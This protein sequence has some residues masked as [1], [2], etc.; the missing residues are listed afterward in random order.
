MCVVPVYSPYK[1]E[2]SDVW[3]MIYRERLDK[4]SIYG[5]PKLTKK[6]DLFF[7]PTWYYLYEF[8]DWG[9]CI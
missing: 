6:G 7:S 9:M 5:Q 8:I 4:V 3:Y 1:G 2:Q